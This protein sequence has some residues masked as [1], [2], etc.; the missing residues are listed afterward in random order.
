MSEFQATWLHLFIITEDCHNQ[1]LQV[2]PAIAGLP[3]H[4]K[5]AGQVCR[6]ENFSDNWI[7]EQGPKLKRRKKSLVQIIFQY[8]FFL[9]STKKFRSSTFV[10]GR[11]VDI[12][13]WQDIHFIVRLEP[14]STRS[15]LFAN[16][17]TMCLVLNPMHFT[18]SMKNSMQK[19]VIIINQV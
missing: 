9:F 5:T 10:S 18:I 4:S 7:D 15:H 6:A 16:G 19:D 12:P 3:C 11:V 13:D 8:Y 17:N 2:F 1:G 14:V